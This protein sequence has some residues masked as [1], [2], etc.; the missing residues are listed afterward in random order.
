MQYYSRPDGIGPQDALGS[1]SDAT[2]DTQFLGDPLAPLEAYDA[3]HSSV[4]TADIEA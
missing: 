3:G 2:L 1:A 4:T